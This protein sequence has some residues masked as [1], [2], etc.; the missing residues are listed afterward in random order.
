MLKAGEQV[1][2]AVVK[3]VG[4]VEQRS[5]QRRTGR[6]GAVR[7]DGESGPQKDFASVEEFR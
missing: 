5:R 3:R 7:V 4:D 1:F 6:M 2:L